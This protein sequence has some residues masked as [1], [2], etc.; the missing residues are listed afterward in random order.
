MLSLELSDKQ[1]DNRLS[2]VN[3]SQAGAELEASGLEASKFLVLDS[4]IPF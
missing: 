3:E 4:G 2:P 1:Q